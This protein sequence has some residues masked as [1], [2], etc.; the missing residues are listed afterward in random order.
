MTKTHRDTILASW[1]QLLDVLENQRNVNLKGDSLTISSLC[2]IS[3]YVIFFFLDL[4][5]IAFTL[6]I[7][8]LYSYNASVSIDELP[9][10]VAER[11]DASVKFLQAEL[12]QG[13][14]VYGSPAI[15]L[16]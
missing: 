16:P 4:S 14:S 15:F 3:K 8:H 12:A 9:S 1:E 2:A 13:H 5:A 7:S 11:I 10:D 6:L